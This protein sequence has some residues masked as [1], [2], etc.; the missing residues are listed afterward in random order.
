MWEMREYF[1]ILAVGQRTNV[2]TFFG[3]DGRFR[4]FLRN[5]DIAL[6]LII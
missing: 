6:A 3:H 5:F 4:E 1:E 2:G